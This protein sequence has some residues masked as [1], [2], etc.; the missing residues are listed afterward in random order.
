[1]AGVIPGLM[2]AT[3]LRLTTLYRAW[4]NDYPRMPKR[5]LARSA[6]MAFREFDLGYS[7]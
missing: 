3:M 1:M 4:K 7:R 5:E 6:G 2:L